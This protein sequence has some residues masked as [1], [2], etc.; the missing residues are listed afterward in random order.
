MARLAEQL[1]RMP[2]VAAA[3]A[4]G[5]FDL[6]QA[7]LVATLVDLLGDESAVVS[8][9]EGRSVAQLKAAVAGARPVPPRVVAAGGGSTPTTSPTGPTEVPPTWTTSSCSATP[10][11]PSST[12]PAGHSRGIPTSA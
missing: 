4:A 1:K 7:A 3:V 2:A 5:A 9:A 10:T 8:E 6:D 12:N 11:T